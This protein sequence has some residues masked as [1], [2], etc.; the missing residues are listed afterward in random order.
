MAL[1]EQY[2]HKEAAEAFAR[3]LESAPDFEL[4]EVNHALALFYIPDLAAAKQAATAALARYPDS[5]QLH[6]VLALIA[7]LE[8]EPAVAEGHL[9]TVLAADPADFGANLVLGQLLV[10]ET[11]FDEALPVLEIAAASDPVNASAAYSRAMALGRSGRREE[12]MEAMKHFQALRANPA[13]TSFGKIYL[14]QGRYAE[15]LASTGAEDELVDP[16]TPKAAFRLREDAVPRRSGSG[17]STLALADL[18]GD[19]RLDVI[20][21]GRG[22]VRLLRNGGETFQDV[23]GAAG[24]VGPAVAAVGGTTTTTGSWTS[25]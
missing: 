18:D 14:E 9:K 17:E 1:L 12:A 25:W 16:A 20:E 3:A 11:R 5:L 13:H 2:N 7:R 22:G 23:T 4:A 6:Y 10:D 21:A 15:G 24:V 19:G 8:D